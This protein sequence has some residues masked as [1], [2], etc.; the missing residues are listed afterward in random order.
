[1]PKSSFRKA[2]PSQKRVQKKRRTVSSRKRASLMLLLTGLIS[3]VGCGNA[4]HL[5]AAQRDTVNVEAEGSAEECSETRHEG[6][7]SR[8]QRGRRLQIVFSLRINAPPVAAPGG[9]LVREPGACR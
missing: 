6:N 4:E 1:M 8:S 7:A 5:G 2:Q 9:A 3:A